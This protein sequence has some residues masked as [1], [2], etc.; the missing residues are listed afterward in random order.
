M[1]LLSDRAHTQVIA[2]Y[3]II[4]RVANRRALTS[5]SISGTA[6]SLHFKSQG[7]MD[8][9]GSLPDGESMNSTEVNG[10]V[11]GELGTGGESAIEE[12]P[13]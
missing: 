8:S 13:L 7:S 2:P 3:L 6:G 5:E 12:V 9:D 4:L 10:E 11:P 1:I